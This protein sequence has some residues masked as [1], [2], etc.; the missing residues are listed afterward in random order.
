M[1]ELDGR[2]RD[3]KLFLL[4]ID[5]TVSL[6]A[7]P[8]D[9]TLPFVKLI[10]KTGKKYV[11][12]TNNSTKSNSDYVE[13]FMKMGIPVD[14]TSFITAGTALMLYLRENFE[15]ASKFFVVGTQSICR[16]IER[17][18]F[19]TTTEVENVSAVIVCFDSELT[20]DKITGACEIL[21]TTEVPYIATN[22]D[23]VCPV[24]FGMI[25]DCGSVCNMIEAATGKKP[26]YVGKPNSTIVELAV[27][28]N[29]CSIDETIV[30]GDRLYTDIA[31]GIAANAD[32]LVVFTG[33]AKPEDLEDTEF[34]PTYYC[35]SIKDLYEV[36]KG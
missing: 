32:T 19:I 26:I 9:G 2:V 22:P 35:E 20:F 5:G 13:K 18:G 10:N 15:K 14:E 4:D 12:I 6:D 11:F 31:A 16:E 28:K 3:K 29:K 36:L 25:P 24:S 8:I 7:T 30:I 23:L 33:E 27:R 34:K 21:Q 1:K 17:Q